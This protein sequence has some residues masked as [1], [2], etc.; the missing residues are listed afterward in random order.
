MTAGISGA[1]ITV[2]LLILTRVSG[3]ILSAPLIGDAEVPRLVKAG[4]AIALA[5]VLA[6]VPSLARANVPTALLP[7]I[8]AVAAQL[9][10]GVALG[11]VAR[12]VFFAVQT[13]GQLVSLQIGL[14]NA[15]VFNPMS[16]LPDAVTVQLY[17]VIAAL[18]FLALQGD[19]WLVMSLA[20][21]FDLAPLSGAAFSPALLNEAVSAAI[22]VTQIGVQIA[23]PIAVS[24]FGANVVLGVLSRSLPQLN[25][26]VLSL[27]LD[28]LLG[29]LAIGGSLAGIVLVI[30][31]LF[32]NMPNAM[33]GPL[34]G[35]H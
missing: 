10:V 4:V 22:A 30:E 21:S 25:V 29:L 16:H 14:S 31:H 19:G 15:A 24:L 32:G 27:P 12:A 7:F 34:M 13:A 6:Q 5:V 35:A 3:L 20:R 11:F 18:T 1:G 23:L 33:L 26:F 2:F 9:L 28:L 17:T 8:L